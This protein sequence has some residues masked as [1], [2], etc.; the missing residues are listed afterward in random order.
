MV[1]DDASAHEALIR[2]LLNKPFKIPIPNYVPSS[3]GRSLGLKRSGGRQ[4]LHDPYD[5]GALVLYCPPELSEHD[6][7]KMNENQPVHV[8]VDPLLCKAQWII[9][10][11]S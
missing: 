10:P 5:P 1:G 2:K 6:K 8:V 7:L 9:L 11:L 4:P 3:Y